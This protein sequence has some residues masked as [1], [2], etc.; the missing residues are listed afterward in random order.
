MGH[1]EMQ[2]VRP[3][4]PGVMTYGRTV[5]FWHWTRKTHSR[6]P[7]GNRNFAPATLWQ[8][9]LGSQLPGLLFLVEPYLLLGDAR[10]P[11]LS[12]TIESKSWNFLHGAV[13]T[14]MIWDLSPRLKD[15]SWHTR[16]LVIQMLNF[17]K[18]KTG[19]QIL[20]KVIKLSDISK[21]TRSC[22]KS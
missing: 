22:R 16:S 3:R 13:L 4:N 21:N 17:L 20:I 11:R 2:S 19:Q 18:V 12:M 7:G 6:T 14:S 8:S 1:V 5:L 9:H 10:E 15:V